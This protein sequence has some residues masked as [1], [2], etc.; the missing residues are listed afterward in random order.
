[1]MLQPGHFCFPIY[2]TYI[3]KTYTFCSE[4]FIAQ[5]ES[6]E[7]FNSYTIDRYGVDT[8]LNM[9]HVSP[10]LNPLCAKFFRGNIKHTFFVISPH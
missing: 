3:L 5:Y 1:M 10:G 4:Q 9:F 2:Y 8:G 7:T 6:T